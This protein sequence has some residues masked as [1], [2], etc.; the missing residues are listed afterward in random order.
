MAGIDIDQYAQVLDQTSKP[1]PG[2][3]AAGATTGG[4]EG[5]SDSVYI[6]GLIKSGSFGLIAAERIAHLQGKTVNIQFPKRI[7]DDTSSL[8]K[9]S[10]TNKNASYGLERFPVLRSLI[11]FGKPIAILLGLLAAIITFSLLPAS[12]GWLSSLIALGIGG[13][14]LVIILGV[15]ELIVLIT[16]FLIPDQ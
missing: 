5:G 8:D 12:L 7:G 6:G 13:F 10:E 3:F 15:V 16:E 11:R 9:T 4:L 14:F 1:I 2:V